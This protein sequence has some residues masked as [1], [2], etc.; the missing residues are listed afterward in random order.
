MGFLNFSLRRHEP[1]FGLDIGHSSMKVMQMDSSAAS[2][3]NPRIMGYGS[4]YRYAVSSIE[5]GVIV[6]PRALS[7]A[8][9][10]LF[11]TRL[12]GSISTRRV[13][14]TIPM[15][16]SFSRPLHL[17]AMDE[18]NLGEAV[19][20]EA[21][22]YIPENPENLYIDYDI[23]RQD[24]KGIE[25]LLVATPKKIIESYMKFLES[26]GLEPLAL[27]PTMNA[28]ARIFG[29]ADPGSDV[30]TVL[31]DFGA[32]ATDIAVFDKTLFVNSTVQGGSSTM[33]D[34]IAK[35]LKISHEEA[36]DVKNEKGMGTSGELREIAEAVRPTLDNL[37]SG[38]DKITRYFNERL[39]TDG[40]KISQT[41]MI[42]GGANMPGLSGYL[43]KELG[44]DVRLLN[45][46]NRI[47][48]GK[49]A[50]P[51]ILERSMFIT[52]AGCAVLDMSEVVN[53]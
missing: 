3:K 43:S 47:D 17:P 42:G 7:D 29:Y 31:V 18:A 20:L 9:H 1:L 15:S 36:Y 10:D 48:F 38:I 23:V 4:S 16:N 44:M 30:P 53:D 26:I 27:E 6:D 11:D 22:Q 49:L 2:A 24:D 21:E 41:I 25:L 45:P 5:N 46:W 35:R 40:R 19:R 51:G 52:V 33:I 50:Q 8:L 13:V 32:N 28:T 14:C 12:I 34:L 37:V 39:S